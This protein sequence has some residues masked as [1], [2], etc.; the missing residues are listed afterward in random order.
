MYPR[1]DQ[2]GP[3]G[4]QVERMY[5]YVVACKC[6]LTEIRKVEVIEDHD[7]RQRK[8]VRIEVRCKKEPQEVAILKVPKP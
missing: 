6:P 8:P 5:D 3:D 4:V 7:S 2:R 1:A